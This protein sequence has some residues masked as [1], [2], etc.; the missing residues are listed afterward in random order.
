M[1]RSAAKN[2]ER[3]AVV[4]DP[5]RLR[6]VLAEIDAGG[7]ISEATR[8][9]L[10][11]K[12]FAHTRRVRRRH[13]VA[14][15]RFATPDAPPAD[16]PETLHV[17]GLAG[18]RAALRREPAPD[19]GVLRARRRRGGPVAGARRRCCRA[20]S[21]PTTTSSTSTRRCASCAEFA[22]PAAAI[23][24]HNN[25]CGAAIADKGVADAYRRARE[26]DPVSAF[27]GIVARQPPGRRRAGARADGDLPRVRDRAGVRARARWRSLAAKKNLRL[28]ALRHRAR[29][30][31]RA[32]GAQRRGRPPGADARSRHRAAAA[33]REGRR[34]SAPPTRRRAARPRLRLAGLQARQVERHRVRARAAARWASAP[35]RCRASIRCGSPCRRRARRCAGSVVGVGRVL[36][37]PRRRRRGGQGRRRRRHPA[38]RLGARRR[39][40]SPPPTSTAWRWS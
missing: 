16:F 27:G 29:A 17:S 8:F 11:R 12:A 28:L 2:H 25:P 6:R 26:T 23:V 35:A 30:A 34:R 21:S 24:K 13:R 37:V 39:G 36:P 32:R 31:G 22:E 14:P 7:E 38:G 9:R 5:G 1:I 4:V 10:A 3:V 40:R 33:A 15:G 18:A 20:R 19:G